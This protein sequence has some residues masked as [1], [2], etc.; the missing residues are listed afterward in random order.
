MRIT[1]LLQKVAGFLR[2]QRVFRVCIVFPV[3]GLV[4][5]C[6]GGCGQNSNGKEKADKINSNPV[7]VTKPCGEFQCLN[8]KALPQHL[9]S[10]YKVDFRFR[11]N[12][13]DHNCR[14]NK[15]AYIQIARVL[16]HDG[17]YYDDG[18]RTPL[19]VKDVT[20]NKGEESPELNGWFIDNWLDA[21]YGYYARISDT[22]FDNELI[23]I[24]S[25][26]ETPGVPAWL[27]DRPT[28]LPKDSLVEFVD[29]P[30]CLD[31]DA[32]CT[33]KLLGYSHWWFRL[34][35]DGYPPSMEGPIYDLDPSD[36]RLDVL[37]HA[38]TLAVTR[39]NE[40]ATSRGSEIKLFPSNM[41]AMR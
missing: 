15:I 41:I 35:N 6:G 21:K 26:I 13:C 24:G 7:Q 17:T 39:W 8:S 2:S 20:D 25:N 37:K 38:V 31:P 27:F 36:K 3:I 29:V 28:G 34:G 18:D 4:L 14:C 32:S 30:V 22:A 12:D 10:E 1:I 33:N 9:G 23:G 19:I 5:I 16:L 40:S 11:P